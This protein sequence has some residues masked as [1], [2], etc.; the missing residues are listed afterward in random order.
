MA[1][2]PVSRTASGS[3]Q[4]DSLSH[5]DTRVNIPTA[6]MQSFFQREEDY[7][8]RP[9]THYER[10]R[11]LPEGETRPRDA[12]RDPQIIWNGVR[13]TLTEA[14][15]KQL[16]ET[17][18]IEI[19]DAQLVWR[20]KDTQDWSD[21]IVQ[22][23]PLY[24]QEKIHPKAIIEDLKRQAAAN[25]EAKA[26]V[27]DLFAD[28]NG[29]P[30][31]AAAEFYQH[32]Q[33]WS[34]R[35]ILGD[36]L[37]VMA[38]LAERERLKG[39]VQCIYFD[40]PYGIK[41]NSNWQVST[42]SRDV[43]DGKQ[44][45][46]SR[47]PE[48]VKAFRDT[49]KDGIHSY[50]TYLRDRLTV[51]RDL[52]TE[53]GSIFVQIGDEN[54]HRVRAVMD[55]V[56]G[57]KNFRSE[58]K[59][60]TT[61]GHSS[62]F[63]ASVFD[64]IIWYTKSDKAKYRPLYFE[65][66]PGDEGA[67][68]YKYGETSNGVR[69]SLNALAS[70][71]LVATKVFQPYPLVSM[72]PNA[73]DRGVNFE[74]K[75][76]YPTRGRHWSVRTQ[77]TERIAR[78]GRLFSQ[79]EN[80]RFTYFLEDYPVTPYTNIWTDT[81]TSGFGAEAIYVV[82]TLPRVIER[83]ILMTT[84]PG[85]LVLDPTCGSGSTAYVAEQ[86]GRRWIT[87]DTSRVALALARTRLMS[88]RY[89]WY[90]LADSPEGRRKEAELLGRFPIDIETTQSDLRQGFVYERVPHVTLKSIANNSR[91]DD[92]WERFQAELQALRQSLNA[93][94]KKTWEEWEI[95]REAGTNWP[96]AAMAT[97][98][99]WW[100]ARIARQKEIDAAIAQAADVEMLYDRPYIDNSRIRVA[101]PFTVESLSPHR[102][103]AADE[104]ELIDGYDAAKGKRR[105]VDAAKPQVDFSQIV[106]EYL[107][108]SGVHQSDKGRKINFDSVTP[109]PGQWVGAEARFMEGDGDAAVMRRAAILIGPEYGTISRPDLTAAAREANEARFDVLIACAFNFDAHSSELTQL[110][111]LPILKARM[112]PDLHMADELKNTG[113]GNLFVVFGEPDIDIE[114][115]DTGELRVQV[116]GVDVYDPNTGEIRSNDV[117]DIAAWFIDTDYNEES[118]FVRHAYFLGA[119]DPYKA[120][121]TALCAEIDE[122]AWATLYSATS[123]PFARPRDGV[124]AVKVINHFGDEVMKVY[125]V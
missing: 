1:R 64:S 36:S 81:Q 48:Q 111:P 4:V 51:I 29:V 102:I 115:L 85:D 77:G 70:N 123:R 110:G 13:I 116:N 82:Q 86:W 87:V 69:G 58:I 118:F 3:K 92:I 98:T 65:R 39:K 72:N 23:P 68:Q 107:K 124:I 47:E 44:A 40:P 103:I 113:K 117:K 30:K 104:D 89:F 106:I 63:I 24:I 18:K 101:G 22:T 62:S 43:K 100:N 42:Q 125:R 108:T 97:H 57:E 80:L 52:L 7:S 35:M 14:Q 10:G 83:C 105:R 56:F 46:I 45:D 96:A 121:K 31:S 12:D 109:W 27:P 88:A 120:L 75:T 78:T 53:S 9:P 93:A 71:G 114:T 49:W 37:S 73:T 95:P 90:L 11:P 60:K 21:L 38:S 112:N 26:D 15:R 28:F 94:L 8:P 32:P 67:T 34:N 25:A 41:F 91:I 55:E 54:V 59:F 50:L 17:G 19:G 99:K 6:E 2:R 122:D 20:G 61:G 16:A 84:D 76:F 79:G 66:K 33:H 74:G 119:N 5:S